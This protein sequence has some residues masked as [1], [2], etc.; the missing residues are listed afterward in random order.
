MIGGVLTSGVLE[1]LIY[2]VIYMIWRKRELP[3]ARAPRAITASVTKPLL[4]VLVVGA[5]ITAAVVIYRQRSHS[6]PPG[7]TL[8]EAQQT[9]VKEV[10]NGAAAIS[11]GLAADNVTNYNAAV[12]KLQPALTN[13]SQSFPADHPWKPAL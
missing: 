13:I 8:T 10:F 6:T 1:L 11:A 9:A 7:V 3:G 4:A 12:E 2:P 5:L